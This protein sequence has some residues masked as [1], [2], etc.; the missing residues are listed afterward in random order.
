MDIE[1]I[2]AKFHEKGFKVTPPRLAICEYVLSSKDH[3]TTDML[4]TEM[5]RKYPTVSLATVYQT[6]HL[7]TNIGL[8]HELNLNIRIS[9][10][11][12]KTSSHIN[13]IC[14]NCG[15][16]GDYEAEDMERLWYKIVE[17]LGFK[18]I[19]KRIDVYR[20][21]DQCTESTIRSSTRGLANEEKNRA[22]L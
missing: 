8:L 11:D 17:G 19:G 6:L 14:K 15:M 20:Y 22:K 9:R 1:R 12:P 21:C 2:I 4:Y 5:K 13:I 16:V 3:P 18:P 10:Y 7:L